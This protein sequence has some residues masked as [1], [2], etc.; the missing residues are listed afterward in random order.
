MRT[1][2][3]TVAVLALGAKA[4]GHHSFAAVYLEDQDRV[5]MRGARN[6]SGAPHTLSHMV[7]RT[8][9]RTHCYVVEWGR[10]HARRDRVREET[11]GPATMW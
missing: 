8:T 9:T 4:W 3:L 7:E 5:S 6:S 11:C 2:F 1:I 10:H